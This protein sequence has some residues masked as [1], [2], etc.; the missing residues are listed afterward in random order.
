MNQRE[1]YVTVFVL[2]AR[3]ILKK[4]IVKICNEN[5]TPV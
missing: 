1:N 4:T 3:G 2:M 5:V